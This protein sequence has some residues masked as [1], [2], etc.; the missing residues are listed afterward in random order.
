M[1][2]LWNLKWGPKLSRLLP[3]AASVVVAR[4]DNL[5]LSQRLK[6]HLMGCW[7]GPGGHVDPYELPLDAARREVS[8]E[9]GL[10]LPACAFKPLGAK[11]ILFPRPYLMYGVFLHLKPNQWPQNTEPDKHTKWM[12][13]PTV[14]GPL[15]RGEYLLVPGLAHFIRKWKELY[16]RP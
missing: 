5:I 14:T 7:Q 4:K 15:S 16:A 8:E 1:K 13:F 9:M 3:R 10:T 6:G 2:F 12:Q 11:L